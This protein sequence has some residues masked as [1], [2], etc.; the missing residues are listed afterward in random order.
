MIQT[1]GV[2]NFGKL[3]YYL[4]KRAADEGRQT[5]YG[6]IDFCRDPEAICSSTKFTELRWIAGMFYWME[7][8]EKYDV[9][10]WNYLDRLHKFVD[11]GRVDR[12]FIDAVSGIVNRGCHNPVSSDIFVD[13]VACIFFASLAHTIRNAIYAA[14]RDGNG[15]WRG[16]TAWQLH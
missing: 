7:S 5:R 14:L 12:S 4:G 13:F 3:N 9:G 16:G 15:R 8:V 2:C 11:G 6:E 10:G 1:T